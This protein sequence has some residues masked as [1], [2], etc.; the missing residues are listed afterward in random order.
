MYS[1]IAL[2]VF[3]LALAILLVQYKP[4]DIEGFA[5]AA[6]NPVL[7]PACTERSEDAQE[8][9]G[10]IAAFPETD[11]AAAEM[12]LL[13]SKLCCLEADIATPAAGSYRTLP[14]QFRTS[15]DM[16]PASSF[17]GRCLRNAIR[18]R[19]IELVIEKFNGRGRTL[20]ATLCPDAVPAFANLIA[21][22]NLAMVTTCLTPQPVM[23]RPLGARDLGFWEPAKVADLN[24]YK[25]ISAQP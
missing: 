14:L 21:R 18:D 5:V 6:V 19:D 17:V 1:M 3:L 4:T 7:M 24:A 11:E 25:G 20:L 15:H 10:R 16:E 12:R 23:D 13:V 8:I 9:L 2:G 22:T